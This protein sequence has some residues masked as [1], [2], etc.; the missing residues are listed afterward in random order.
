MNQVDEDNMLS[1]YD[2]SKGERGKHYEQYRKGVH[3][4][5]IEPEIAQMFKDPAAVNAALRKLVEIAPEY[6][7]KVGKTN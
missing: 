2:F 7:E 6:I 4:A 3:L 1:E 5:H